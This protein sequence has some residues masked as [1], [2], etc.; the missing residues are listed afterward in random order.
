MFL[1]RE[2]KLKQPIG[3]RIKLQQK[4]CTNN[5]HIESIFVLEIRIS[6]KINKHLIYCKHE[7]VY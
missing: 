1:V 3:I 6:K 7:L 4:E 5:T 2:K